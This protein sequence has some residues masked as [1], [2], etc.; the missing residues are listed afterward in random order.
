MFSLTVG[1]ELNNKPT[2][3]YLLHIFLHFRFT[4]VNT[5]D[6]CLPCVHGGSRHAMQSLDTVDSHSPNWYNHGCISPLLWSITELCCK[7][8]CFS[9]SVSITAATVD[10]LAWLMFGLCGV[11][12]VEEQD[13]CSMC[14]WCQC[15]GSTDQARAGQLTQ[16]PAPALCDEQRWSPAPPRPA[17]TGPNIVGHGASTTLAHPQQSRPDKLDSVF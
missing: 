10:C 4:F 7:L 5:C 16:P 1:Q 3:I 2:L 13:T 11:W 12:R 8:L 15:T 6:L 17:Q 9:M 14:Q